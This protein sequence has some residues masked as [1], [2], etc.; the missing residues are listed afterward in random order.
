LL[1]TLLGESFPRKVIDP[2]F[3]HLL[4]ENSLCFARLVPGA[5]GTM[6]SHDNS[7]GIFTMSYDFFLF[8]LFVSLVFNSSQNR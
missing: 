2:S 3:Y 5:I 8:V 4:G 7:K 6:D 1:Y